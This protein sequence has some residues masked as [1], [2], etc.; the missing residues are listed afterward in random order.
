M[1]S[2][3]TKIPQFYDVLDDE[4][5]VIRQIYENLLKEANKIG[6][7]EIETSSIELRER[8]LNAT[9]VHFSKIFEVQRPKQGNK[10]ALQAD[11]AMSMSRFVADLHIEVPV[12]KM[13]QLG[14]IYRD[15]IHNLP[16]YRREF[17]QILL[18]QWGT[19][20]LFADAE[21][22]F[23]TYSSLK[24][25][26][27]A[28]ISYIEIS[29]INLFNAFFEGLAEKI[30]FKGIETINKFEVDEKDRVILMESF[31]K[32]CIPFSELQDIKEKLK[33]QKAKHQIE[34]AIEVYTLLTDFFEITDEIKF[35]FNNFEGTG[36][37]SG[38]H[39][40]IYI[41]IDDEEYLIA[42]GGRID[43]LCTKFNPN[44]NIPAV[45][46]GIGVQLLAQFIHNEPKKRIVILVD[47]KLIKER[48]STIEILKEKLKSYSVSVIPKAT[49]YKKKFFKSEFYSNCSFILIDKDFFE[50]RSNDKNFKEILLTEI[51]NLVFD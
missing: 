24:K 17:K 6:F 26:S 36:H 19:E 48:W 15:R 34:K 13:I 51:G 32:G 23:L 3:E 43:T 46:M 30:R 47:D 29:N 21:T 7:M 20:S 12:I 11:L 9:E 14:K 39:Y 50:V 40:R 44:K 8:Y 38:L 22:I 33:N 4:S 27:N 37:Y 42:D 31:L 28:K 16:G 25:V 35:S 41:D 18:G 2:K 45:C 10:F 49:S 1:K 5:E